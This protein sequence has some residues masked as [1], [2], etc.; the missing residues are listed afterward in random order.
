MLKYYTLK[1]QT[2]IK[3]KKNGIPICSWVVL[4]VALLSFISPNF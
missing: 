3:K 2:P 4:D 1:L